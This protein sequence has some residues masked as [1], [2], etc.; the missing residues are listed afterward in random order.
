MRCSGAQ[1]AQGHDRPSGGGSRVLTPSPK[2]NTATTFIPL[3]TLR[4]TQQLAPASAYDVPDPQGLAKAIVEGKRE[5]DRV[6]QNE[7]SGVSEASRLAAPATRS[8]DGLF[9]IPRRAPLPLPG[10]LSHRWLDGRHLW[11]GVEEGV[12]IVLDEDEHA[13]FLKLRDGVAPATV[14]R[15]F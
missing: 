4:L 5:L 14:V 2:R 7:L 9:T 3:S 11:I 12:A 6:T 15:Q 10:T 8:G 1:F 13:L